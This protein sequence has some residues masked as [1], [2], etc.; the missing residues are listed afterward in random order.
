VRVGGPEPAD[1]SIQP[2]LGAAS[3]RRGQIANRSGF[4]FLELG[5]ALVSFQILRRDRLM[6]DRAHLLRFTISAASGNRLCHL[7]QS[8]SQRHRSNDDYLGRPSPGACLCQ[9]GFLFSSE[10]QLRKGGACANISALFGR[11]STPSLWASDSPEHRHPTGRQPRGQTIR[12]PGDAAVRPC[13]APDL[14]P[15]SDHPRPQ[16]RPTI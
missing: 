9:L 15:R 6:A 13:R 12:R 11:R 3:D 10:F 4:A 16:D 14:S 5:V 2:N 7:T 1:S 8:K